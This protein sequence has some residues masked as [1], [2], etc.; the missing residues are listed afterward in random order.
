MQL[1]CINRNSVSDSEA[2]V[3]YRFMKSCV[4]W[5]MALC[6]PLKAIKP[7]IPRYMYPS[8]VPTSYLACG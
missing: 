6:S 4:F 2:R 1:R 7:T 3:E 8:S 5:D